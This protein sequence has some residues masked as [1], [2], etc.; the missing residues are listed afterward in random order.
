MTRTDIAEHTIVVTGLRV[1]MAA[2]AAKRKTTKA[3]T[4]SGPSRRLPRIQRTVTFQTA[5]A[6]ALTA[7]K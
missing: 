7:C 2:T 6:V 3:K 4:T 1:H 5:W